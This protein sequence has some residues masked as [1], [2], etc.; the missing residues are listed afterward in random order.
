MQDGEMW[1]SK[2]GELKNWKHPELELFDVFSLA[3][4]EVC[5]A[6]RV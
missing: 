4:R 2:Q 1:N 5:D 6:H 3:N